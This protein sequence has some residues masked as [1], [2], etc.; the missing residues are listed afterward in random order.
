VKTVTAQLNSTVKTVANT[1]KKTPTANA[2]G[3]G[4]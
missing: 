4:K 3:G 2:D 1:G